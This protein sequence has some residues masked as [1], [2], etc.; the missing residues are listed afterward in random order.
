[1]GNS[2]PNKAA[3]K[4]P[5]EALNEPSNTE[6]QDNKENNEILEKSEGL[7]D[8]QVKSRTPINSQVQN[9]SEIGPVA[10]DI[11]S[12]NKELYQINNFMR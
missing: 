10:E 3:E 7:K 5:G 4:E 11:E 6:K 12:E 2:N 9:L 8:M 1:M